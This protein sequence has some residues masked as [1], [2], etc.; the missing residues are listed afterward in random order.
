VFGDFV[1]PLLLESSGQALCA[2]LLDDWKSLTGL[3]AT[4]LTPGLGL[5]RHDPISGQA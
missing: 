2:V 5:R 3:I 4:L 1:G